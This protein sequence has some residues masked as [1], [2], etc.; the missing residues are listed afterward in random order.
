MNTYYIGIDVSKGYSDFVILDENKNEIMGSFKLDDTRENH[1]HLIKILRQI[2]SINECEIICGMESTGGYENNWYNTLLEESLQQSYLKVTRINPFG[3][4]FS[5]QA[6]LTK[7]STDKISAEHIARFMIN[8]REILTY[9]QRDLYVAE[10]KLYKY[11]YTIS[12]QGA[13]YRNQL[14]Q[15]L[16]ICFP[17]LIRFTVNKIPEWILHFLIN[18]PRPSSL[19]GVCKNDV[20]NEIPYI[21]K[22]YVDYL[23]DVYEKSVAS[24]DNQHTGF[25]I[26]RFAEKILSINNEKKEIIKILSRSVNKD[27]IDLLMTIPGIGL[28]T[29]IAALL[30]I[31]DISRFKS[32]KKLSSFFGLIPVFNQSGD[33]VKGSKISKKGNRHMR[34]VLFM[35]AKTAVKNKYFKELFNFYKTKNNN[36]Y[37]ALTCVMHKLLRIIFGVLKNN[38]SFDEKIDKNY[39]F[40]SRKVWKSDGERSNEKYFVVISK[41][42]PVSSKEAGK[43]KQEP[44]QNLKYKFNTGSGSHSSF[45]DII[46]KQNVEISQKK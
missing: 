32:A 35:A 6:N 16:Y 44:S 18:Y 38:K 20:I 19:N 34:R 30:Y 22:E 12:K 8:H 42:A 26:K 4:Y 21:K 37:F 29:A 27:L 40:T 31:G 24:V 15:L 43:R 33:C 17:E 39:R 46:I 23:F 14:Q 11:H 3:V 1:E 10:K 45:D 25:L 5:K 2:Q 7:T 9:N 13:D 41:H 36:Y 28:Q